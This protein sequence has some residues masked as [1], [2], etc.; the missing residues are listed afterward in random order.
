MHDSSLISKK[1]KLTYWISLISYRRTFW[2]LIAF[3]R[4]NF[5]TSAGSCRKFDACIWL[6]DRK[7]VW[8]RY[9]RKGSTSKQPPMSHWTDHTMGRSCC[10]IS[11][12]TTYLVCGL[13]NAFALMDCRKASTFFSS[14]CPKVIPCACIGIWEVHLCISWGA[15]Y[16]DAISVET[17][18]CLCALLYFRG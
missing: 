11:A 14:L 1:T 4:L 10:C 12:S 7:S 5:F 9:L 17:K 3:I 16:V 13:F 2:I 18:I 6:I 8:H 15:R